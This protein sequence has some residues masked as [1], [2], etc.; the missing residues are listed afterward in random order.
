MRESESVLTGAG[1]C[2]GSWLTDIYSKYRTKSK[3]KRL[4][5]TKANTVRYCTPSG[6][7]F[8][9]A[10]LVQPALNIDILVGD[11][12]ELCIKL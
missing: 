8:G 1:S 4:E 12:R 2:A 6:T 5:N 10:V 11:H 7:L 9:T 3:G